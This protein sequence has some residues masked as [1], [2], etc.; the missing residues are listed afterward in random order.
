MKK[1]FTTIMVVSL[2]GNVVPAFNIVAI[3]TLFP[4]YLLNK[5]ER[6]DAAV[7]YGPSAARKCLVAAYVYW[8]CSY[9]VT[10]APIAN[11]LSFDFLRFDGALLI[12]YVPL[13][14]VT[15][16]RLD[17]VFV[18]RSVSLFLSAMSAVAL[19]GLAEFVDSTVL[20]LGL[21]WLPAPL[22][23]MHDASLSSSIFHGFFRAHNAAGAVYAMAAL[24][25]FSLLVRSKSPS[26]MSWPSVWLAANVIGLM[27]TQSRTAYVAF[28]ATAVVMF[29]RSRWSLKNAIKYGA[30]V[31]A[32]LLYFLLLAPTVSHRT[33]EVSDLEDPNVV[34]RFFYYQRAF[35]DFTQSPIVGTGFGRFN[36]ELKIYSGVPHLLYIATG[37]SVVN[38][39]AHA[40]NSYLHFL[41]EGGVVGLGLMLGVW[42]NTFRW[43]RAQKQIFEPG[44]FGDCF[45][46]GIQA[47]I[48][49]E[50]IMSLTEHMMGT[51][52]SSLTI[53][54]MVALFLNLVGWKYRIASL[55]QSDRIMWGGLQQMSPFSLVPTRLQ[56]AKV[57]C[58]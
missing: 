34:T 15:D 56:A 18:R 12:A 8:I 41:A 46:Q 43:V 55:M 58:P 21:S 48:I 53:L 6:T 13:L 52:V 26:L 1:T 57:R 33:Q 24:L 31:I 10:S 11:L 45:A 27:L 9:L 22:Q 54:T 23:L 16:L 37:G 40:H 14:L 25:A 4:L 17:P 29:S 36:D 50:F 49:L 7:N 35:T 39:D 5:K 28:F 38:D 42:I 19:L 30:L 20:P 47:C 51:A 3:S 44:S 2:V 32:P